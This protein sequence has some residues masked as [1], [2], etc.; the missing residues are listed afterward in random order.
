MW[1]WRVWRSLRGFNDNSPV[2]NFTS[3]PLMNH[4]RFFELLQAGAFGFGHEAPHEDELQHHHRAE[5]EEGVATAQLLSEV[6]KGKGNDG[7]QHPVR[8]G[9]QGLAFG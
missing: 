2:H 9:A 3:S 1:W 5:E 8:A 7:R 4:E 6:W